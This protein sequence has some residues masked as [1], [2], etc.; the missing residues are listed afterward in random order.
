M[1]LLIMIDSRRKDLLASSLLRRHIALIE[2]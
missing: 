1:K 2:C